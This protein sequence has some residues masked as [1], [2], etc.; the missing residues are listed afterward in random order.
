MQDRKLL[1][2]WMVII[3]SQLFM[4]L[5]AQN[6]VD[7]QLTAKPIGI[8]WQSKHHY[9]GSEFLF[10]DWMPGEIHLNN[11]QIVKNIQLNYNA[12][13]DALIYAAGGMTPV[14]TSKYHVKAFR[15]ST[16]QGKRFF[17]LSDFDAHLRADNEDRQFYELLYDGSN[18]FYAKRS[19]K[20]NKSL[21]NDNPFKKSVYY[22]DDEYLINIKG[23]WLTRPQKPAS[24]Y[25]YYEKSLV[26]NI[27]RKNR[28]SLKR[29]EDLVRFLSELDELS[30]TLPASETKNPVNP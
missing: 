19:K 20:I 16:R 11:G 5:N 22:R 8:V 17:I 14:E 30:K 28:L 6:E 1:H 10:E 4:T 13:S 23:D 29:E 27:I 3:I 15:V 9:P 2:L 18:R 21:V 24:Y 25:P 7:P 12:Y 26:K